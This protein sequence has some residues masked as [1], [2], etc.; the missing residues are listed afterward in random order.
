MGSGLRA[1]EY[2]FHSMAG[3]DGLVDTAVKTARSGYLQRCLIKNLE[4]LKVNYDGS[5]RND[6]N[7]AV[8]QFNYGE[9]GLDITQVSYVKQFGLYL[10]NARQLAQNIKTML[11][12]N[13]S[14]TIK[15]LIIKANKTIN[16]NQLTLESIGKKDNCLIS[17]LTNEIP[18]T[19]SKKF[20]AFEL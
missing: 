2:Y 16:K 14:K 15:N 7:S 10:R 13:Y 3:R 17:D 4:S 19:I 5:V 20:D 9:D 6:P 1:Q 11:K 12:T 8:V 18:L